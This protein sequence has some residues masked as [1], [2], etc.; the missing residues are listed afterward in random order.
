MFSFENIFNILQNHFL[1]C[2]IIVIEL[3]FLSLKFRINWK[4]DKRKKIEIKN[5]KIKENKMN[6]VKYNIKKN[7]FI[8]FFLIIKFLIM[9]GSFDQNMMNNK[10]G[11]IELK[12]S[13]VSVKVKG[14][15]NR[16]VFSQDEE[17]FK[18]ENFP[19]EIHINDIKQNNVQRTYDLN[20]EENKKI[21]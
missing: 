8:N 1:L 3:I 2:L 9:I 11:L 21:I 10:F 13:Y 5:G 15:G 17:W 7:R 6:K 20:Q 16:C 12:S 14:T 18:N 4:E 19:N